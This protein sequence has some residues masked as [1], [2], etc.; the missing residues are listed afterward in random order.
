[1][2]RWLSKYISLL[3]LVPGVL[4]VVV[5]I[6]NVIKAQENWSESRLISQV[7]ELAEQSSN[8]VHELQKE[9]GMSAGFLGS[10]GA[11]FSQSLKQQRSLTDAK[12]ASLKE[13]V[14]NSSLRPDVEQVITTLVG[15]LNKL[16]QIRQQVD[17]LSIAL[18]DVL[19][20]YTNNN[21]LI[22][23]ITANTISK[24]SSPRSIKQ[25]ST[26]YN[27]AYAKE[28]S[29]IER[30]VLS[31]VFAQGAFTPIL[32]Q[33]FIDL[34]TKQ[35]TYFNNALVYADDE[36]YGA[37]SRFMNS[38]AEKKVES[39]RT[40]ARNNQQ[41]NV[42]PKE[43][44]D[45][46]TARINDLKSTEEQLISSILTQA[47]VNAHAA[48]FSISVQVMMMLVAIV[49]TYFLW[50]VVKIRGLQSRE[51]KR[52]MDEVVA[53][54]DLT[55]I[56]QKISYDDLG[57]IADRLNATF[58]MFKSDLQR[59]QSYATEIS[60]ATIQTAAAAD[61][62][63]ANLVKQQE[64]ILTIVT[65]SDEVNRSIDNIKENMQG[66][67]N[68]V[69]DAVDETLRGSETVTSATKEITL[70]SEQVNNIG[71]TMTN[72]NNQVTN[73]LGMV[74]VIQAVADQTN[75]L[76][77]NAAIEAARAGE[78]G[79]GFA[80]VADEVRTLAQRTR[81]STD[82]IAVIV[83]ELNSG[84]KEAFEVI[85]LSTQKVQEAVVEA[86]N[87]AAVLQS[88][89]GIMIQV[90]GST[91]RISDATEAQFGAI[92]IIAQNINRIHGQAKENVV[93]T[94]QIA[95]STKQLSSIATKMLERVAAYKTA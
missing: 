27:F 30:A 75:L 37:L 28:Q 6:V 35:S 5:G 94:E 34:T 32:L 61:Q 80:V 3:T 79:R 76:A 7:S 22:L 95:A 62:S 2:T 39:Y 91:S 60:T 64:D 71:S 10:Q 78:Q 11:D 17:S 50:R 73:I 45:A 68:L 31:N 92:S 25:F 18:P 74:D 84:S 9:R 89:I 47:A 49:F 82:E 48:I 8:L 26:L 85:N 88:L 90:N 4:L 67:V 57:D 23:E 36:F 51:I 69:T 43:W 33:R 93:G 52:V 20:F 13:F 42:N 83:D 15:S 59:F 58:E 86:N 63:E 16:P 14:S 29:G 55:K 56:V 19:A 40:I 41:F 24:L 65:A 77:L 12:L 66:S 87:I 38:S 46:A 72:L 54:H 21:K 81:Q 1:M 70:L 53:H 44:F